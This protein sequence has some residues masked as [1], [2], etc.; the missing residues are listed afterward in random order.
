MLALRFFWGHPEIKKN[1]YKLTGCFIIV[2]QKFV[3]EKS[4][5]VQK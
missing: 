5:E 3:N 1:K 4:T 2:D